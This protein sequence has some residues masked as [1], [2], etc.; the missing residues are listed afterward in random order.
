MGALKEVRTQ[1]ITNRTHITF[2]DSTPGVGQNPFR[3][4]AGPFMLQAG[5]RQLKIET[6]FPGSDIKGSETIKTDHRGV[7]LQQYHR[8]LRAQGKL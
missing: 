1:D 8:E 6:R 2:V 3:E 5:T 7:P 4:W